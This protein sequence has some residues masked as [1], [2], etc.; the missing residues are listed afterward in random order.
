MFYAFAVCLHFVR[1]MPYRWLKNK[2]VSS[3]AEHC[4][5]LDTSKIPGDISLG[6]KDQESDIFP[7]D[8]N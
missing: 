4:I 7:L 1:K 6:E 2:L 8:I 3:Y 5:Y